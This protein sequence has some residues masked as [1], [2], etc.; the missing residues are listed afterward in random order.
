MQPKGI[1]GSKSRGPQGALGRERERER[2]R[3]RERE[4]DK[5]IETERERETD[6]DRQTETETETDR[7]RQRQRLCHAS[8]VKSE[9]VQG[10]L[11]REKS[12]HPENPP[13]TLGIGLR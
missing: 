8:Q 9:G 2:D 6:R 4:T 12:Q 5:Q 11:A 7:D 3:E 1:L 13:R 10:Y